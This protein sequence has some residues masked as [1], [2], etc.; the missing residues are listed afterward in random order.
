[1]A[2]WK[3]LI[4]EEKQKKLTTEISVKKAEKLKISEIP[5]KILTTKKSF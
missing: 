4:D 2:F 3:A 1:M 5:I